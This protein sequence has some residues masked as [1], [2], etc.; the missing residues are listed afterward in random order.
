MALWIH[1]GGAAKGRLVIQW[2]SEAADTHMMDMPKILHAHE[3]I[4]SKCLQSGL[5]RLP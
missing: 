5:W 4:C 1:H 2:S 3:A